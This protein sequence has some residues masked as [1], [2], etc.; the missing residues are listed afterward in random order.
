MD[1]TNQ[2]RDFVVTN[3]LYGDAGALQNDTSFLESGTVDS[4]GM[5]E[6]IMFLESH[7]GLKIEPEEM[8]PE[9]LDSINRVVQF[10]TR[11]QVATR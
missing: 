2:I 9:N 3:F 5:L 4:T 6:L 1:Y 7:Y 8:V 10:V 11:K